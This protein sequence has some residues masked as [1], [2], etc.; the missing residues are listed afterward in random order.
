MSR[1]RYV[2]GIQSFANANAGA[3][4]VRFTADGRELD[5]VA[6]SEERLI[7]RKHP[8]TFPV[9]SL[10]YCMEIF[11]LAS[12]EEIDLVV[13]D[14]FRIKRWHRS[15]PAHN[16][17]EFDY[18]KTKLD[19]P[20]HKIVQISH[21]MAHAASVFY[22]SGFDEAAILI[23][24]GHGSD[25]E[26]TSFLTASNGKIRYLDSYRARGIGAVY[27]AV[28]NWVLGL[29]DGGDGG[30]G[31]TMALAPFGAPH[32][33]VL[34]FDGAFDGIK[35]DYSA[36]MRRMPY[37]D[38]LNHVDRAHRVNPLHGDYRL[39]DDGDD[40]TAPYFARVAYDVQ[41]E[42]ERALVHLG[43]AL[44]ERT[45]CPNL[46]VSGGVALNSVA[47]KV[48]FDA[49][50]FEDIFVFPAC[51]DAG[52][53]FGLA[54]W[55]Y[56][57]AKEL[58]DVR[59]RKLAFAN[60]YTG[61]DYAQDEIDAVLRAYGIEASRTT[62]R[63]VTRLI[64]EGHVVGWFQ[65]ASEYGPRAL[66]HRSILADSRRAE[67][68][69]L[70]NVRVKHRETYRPFAPAVLL[71]DCA[72]Y[73]DL[74]GQS[75]YMLLVA[76]CRKPQVVPAIAH[77]DGTAR[78]QT[79]TREA[80]G[81]FY[82]L[83]AAFKELTGV[84]VILNTSFNDAGEPIVETPEDALICFFGTE[85]D[86]LVLGN[87]LIKAGDQGRGLAGKMRADRAARIAQREQD[88]IGRCFPGYDPVERD[89]YIEAENR[90][91]VW[92][93]SQRTMDEL[94]KKARAWTRTGTRVLVVGTPD[95]TAA[96][97]RQVTALLGVAVVGFVPFQDK[98]DEPGLSGYAS[99]AVPFETRPWS[100]IEDGGYDEILV[101]SHEYLYEIREALT[102]VGV[103]KPVYEI[104]DNA[105]RSLMPTA[106]ARPALLGAKA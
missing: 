8:Y 68:K 37:Y 93:A 4:I 60:A 69:D 65:G 58:G 79:V 102:A 76:N 70:V 41:E 40:V 45:R 103:C 88:L 62:L 33:P 87:R 61:R 31:K 18:L 55:G 97:A 48:M 10:G 95:H 20:P 22:T 52:I 28:T 15:G 80:N 85:L 46:C 7:R 71:Q 51:S 27:A 13:G 50:R 56:Y 17:T 1:Y 35:T 106:G 105:A 11:G 3:S 100:A 83:I 43:Q 29:G 57:N 96:T 49:T 53:P 21:H 14:F 89:R 9:H 32:E 91:A 39:R 74:E 92:H 19:V 47:N 44:Y 101:S 99:T 84:P 5:F 34:S 75:P 94:E 98:A 82:D 78:V 42:T 54:I 2:L 90:K 66:G 30:E 16:C 24:D 59:R 81:V 36:F 26:T 25:L 72:E 104:Y 77:I 12:L 67:I 38:V 63:E 73:F 64:A 23:V 6:I 86:Y